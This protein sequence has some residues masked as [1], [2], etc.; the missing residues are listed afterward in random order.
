M[1]AA[2]LH[3]RVFALAL[4][5]GIP[6]CARTTESEVK[7]AMDA[8]QRERTPERLVTRAH[9]FAT[10][11]DFTRAEQ[12][13][14]AAREAGADERAVAPLLLEVY[15]K[16]R[17]YRDAI[18]CA[19]GFLQHHPTEQHTRLLLATLEAA[20]GY[21]ARAEANLALV[22]RGEPKNADAHYALAVLY[23]H[24][25]GRP[26]RADEHFRAYLQ[27]EPG[28]LHAEE[29]RGSLLTVVE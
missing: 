1:I 17:R 12:Y 19:E 26:A 15:V 10:V 25:L 22:L 28:G 11:G 3:M 27:L 24:D 18:Q 9:V 5:V 20:T 14:L 6:G 29:A 4:A 8:V 21:A 23:Q 13:L 2:K 16:D 7:D